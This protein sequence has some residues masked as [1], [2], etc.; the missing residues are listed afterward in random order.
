MG[1]NYLICSWKTNREDEELIPGELFTHTKAA[2]DTK[3]NQ[4]ITFLVPGEEKI[5]LNFQYAYLL[6]LL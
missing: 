2:T 5:I 4:M 3:G 6:T 1:L